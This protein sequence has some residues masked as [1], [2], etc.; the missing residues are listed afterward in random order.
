MGVNGGYFQV[1][2]RSIFSAGATAG[3]QPGFKVWEG[4]VHF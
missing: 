1:V 4:K 3:P 2:A